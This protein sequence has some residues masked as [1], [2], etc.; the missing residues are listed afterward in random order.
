MKMITNLM[1]VKTIVTIPGADCVQA[2]SELLS[3]MDP[4]ADP[5]NDFYQVRPEDVIEENNK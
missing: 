1:S 3:R 5:C 4:T 2:A